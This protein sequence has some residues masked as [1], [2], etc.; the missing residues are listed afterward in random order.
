[1]RLAPS[2]NKKQQVQEEAEE[3]E[4]LL[5]VEVGRIKSA[6]EEQEVSEASEDADVFADA[7]EKQPVA[8]KENPVDYSDA[9]VADPIQEEEE[10]KGVSDSEEKVVYSAK[11]LASDAPKQS[12]R[13]G[14]SFM[15]HF[16]MSNRGKVC[17]PKSVSLVKVSGD[18]DLQ[19]LPSVISNVEKVD[20]GETYTFEVICIAPK[21]EGQ[22]QAVL[23]LMS[24]EER[25]GEEIPCLINMMS[26]EEEERQLSA[27]ML[28]LADKDKS[29]NFPVG[30][31]EADDDSSSG[32]QVGEKQDVLLSGGIQDIRAEPVSPRSRYAAMIESS[33]ASEKMRDGLNTLFE[34]GYT[35]YKINDTLLTRYEGDSNAAAE[36]LIVH[37]SGGILPQ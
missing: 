6:V 8:E 24:G 12:Y 28:L 7:R 27:S 33:G 14:S 13:P 2:Q 36:H 32:S 5:K 30:S 23:S 21:R 25:F 17:W 35:D 18:E 20:C 26:G 10:K 29:I 37:G 19:V 1:M 3:E 22:A 4:P 15:R 34:L 9:V 11:L 16:T 31:L